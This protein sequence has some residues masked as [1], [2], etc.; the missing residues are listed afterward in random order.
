MKDL[1]HQIRNAPIQGPLSQLKLVEAWTP[2]VRNDRGDTSVL[3]GPKSVFI[4]D[5]G[6]YPNDLPRVSTGQARLSCLGRLLF[7][8]L[9]C[10]T[11]KC[12]GSG[13]RKIATCTVQDDGC[14]SKVPPLLVCKTGYKRHTRTHA[15]SSKWGF[16]GLL[17]PPRG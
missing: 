5:G 14:R 13:F 16:W 3:F 11:P 17:Q 9:S 8:M 10:R 6:C 12:P 4:E 1:A 15:W 7:L 2:V